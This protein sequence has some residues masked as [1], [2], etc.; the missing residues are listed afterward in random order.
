MISVL[1]LVAND[2]IAPPDLILSEQLFEK[3]Q[4]SD[5]DDVAMP[6][7]P[8]PPS[9]LPQLPLLY[10]YLLPITWLGNIISVGT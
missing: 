5:F 6:D 4:R 1:V 2:A 8:Q 3:V 9:Q 7:H 10:A